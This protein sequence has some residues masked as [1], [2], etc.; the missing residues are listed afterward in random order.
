V[1]AILKTDIASSTLTLDSANDIL[2]EASKNTEQSEGDGYGY[3]LQVGVGVSVGAQTGVYAY[4]SL[5][6]SDSDSNVNSTTYNNTTLNADTL[7][8]KS[9]KDVTLNGAEGRANT[10]EGDIGGNLNITSLQDS[11]KSDIDKSG[12]N[13][14]VQVSFGTA[15]DASTQD[16]SGNG[17]VNFA[18]AS[19]EYLGVNQQS[20]L[21]AGD[22][23]YHVN[24]GDNTNLVG[25]MISSS[26]KAIEGNKNTLSTGT[27]T[28]TDLENHSSYSA[29]AIA[30][31]GGISTNNTTATTNSSGGGGVGYESGSQTTYTRSAISEGT[32][33]ITD[34]AKQLSLTGK[35][36]EETLESINHD[37]K[38][39]HT[40]VEQLPDLKALLADQQAMAEAMET[41][42]TT[43]TQVVQDV[44]D[45][46]NVMGNATKIVGG[47]TL[48]VIALAGNII[49]G[50]MDVDNAIASFKDPYKMANTLKSNPELA[51]SLDA[52][53]K[54]EFD[55]LPKTKEGLQT[56]A[57]AT[58]LKVDVLLTTVTTYKDAKG[59]TDGKVIALDVNPEN[60][61]DIIGTLGH[62]DSHVRGGESETLAD[63]SGYASELLSDVAIKNHDSATLDAIKTN[64]GT[65]TDDATQ[66][67]NQ[68]LLGVIIKPILMPI[69]ITPNHF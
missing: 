61:S 39:A 28:T 2:L 49:T 14:K 15:W 54:G 19:G 10:I 59:S 29:G 40:A 52:F 55:N 13:L 45:G 21:F 41:V 69:I 27:L 34:E 22:G 57:D 4:G 48:N 5:N 38:N 53:T 17:S 58:G 25:G 51:A 24:V 62:E 37:T 33:T 68:V 11:V 6:A 63:M 16:T 9:K 67:A 1:S 50:N 20:G 23:G 36:A 35:T 8:I 66:T 65:G 56:L 60:R 12:I 32:I 30:L 18:H 43:G 46:K 7:V 31:S 64:L 44:K 3:G 47:N 26:D 42:T